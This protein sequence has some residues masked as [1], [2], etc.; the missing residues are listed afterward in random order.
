MRQFVTQNSHEITF[1]ANKSGQIYRS[2]TSSRALWKYKVVPGGR[3]ELPTPA[4]S[5]PRS[6][7][8]L[9]RHRRRPRFYG[10]RRVQKRENRGNRKHSTTEGS[11][12]SDE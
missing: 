2:C 9:P 6:T 11:W 12:K 3:I 4:F 8:E 7:N 1:D 5:G 10:E